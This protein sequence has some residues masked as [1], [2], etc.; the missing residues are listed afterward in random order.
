MP[1][2]GSVLNYQ[3]FEGTNDDLADLNGRKMFESL[4]SVKGPVKMEHP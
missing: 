4:S 3:A 1:S 2:R